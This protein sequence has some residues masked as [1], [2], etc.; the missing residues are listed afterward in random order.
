MKKLIITISMTITMVMSANAYKS[1][2]VNNQVFVNIIENE[3]EFNNYI[4]HSVKKGNISYSEVEN[5]FK[6]HNFMTFDDLE[7]SNQFRL[8]MAYA[9]LSNE[10]PCD[11]FR[12]VIVSIGHNGMWIDLIPLSENIVIRVYKK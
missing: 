8:A 2:L 3:N 12:T 11:N 7:I 10:Q 9:K 6:D 1:N 5:F 4:E